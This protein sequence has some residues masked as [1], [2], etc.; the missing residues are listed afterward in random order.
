ME[1]NEKIE[2]IKAAMTGVKYA[3]H[4]ASERIDGIS[5]VLQKHYRRKK[6]TADLESISSTAEQLDED[7]RTFYGKMLW[8]GEVSL[9][10][11]WGMYGEYGEFTGLNADRLFRF[12]R[13]YAESPERTDALNRIKALAAEPRS[14][15]NNSEIGRKNWEAMYRYALTAYDEFC[16]SGSLP[17]TRREAHGLAGALLVAQRHNE[18]NVYQWLK[19][20]GIAPVDA[21]SIGL[22]VMG[23]AMRL[24][25][26]FQN[27]KATGYDFRANMQAVVSIAEEEKRFW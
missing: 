16:K 8:S 7:I 20:V 21:E 4:P 17:G 9:A 27:M 26:L 2:C 12:V 10:I 6:Q 19:S 3:F 5:S 23:Y 22:N 13:C 15:S 25:E 18:A 1:Y 24:K 14:I 11:D